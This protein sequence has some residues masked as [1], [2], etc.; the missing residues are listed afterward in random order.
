ME[1]RNPWYL[2]WSRGAVPSLLISLVLAAGCAEEDAKPKAKEPEPTP[3]VASKQPRVRF[4][5]GAR[6]AT[7]LATALSLPRDQ[8][9]KELGALDC[10]DEVHR[11]VL[12][13]V[14][15]YDLGIYQPLV[16]APMTAPIAVDRVALAACAKAARRDVE[17]PADAVFFREVDLAKGLAEADREAVAK[18]L[19][20]RLLLRDAEGFEVEALVGLHDDVVAELAA[21]QTTT[22][23]AGNADEQWL[24]LACFAVASGTEALFY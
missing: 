17:Q 9:C 23:A 13:G 24:T 6:Y 2:R 8:L 3:V 16:A 22:T 5:G 1:R 21:A 15:P 20:D 11:V 14:E 7:D 12:G 19:Y 18:R 10:V 4:K